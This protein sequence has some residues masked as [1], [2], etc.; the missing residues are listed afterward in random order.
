M[1]NAFRGSDGTLCAV[2]E[3]WSGP[4]TGRCALRVGDVARELGREAGRDFELGDPGSET[5]FTSSSSSSSLSLST[6]RDDSRSFMEFADP[7]FLSSESRVCVRRTSCKR[8]MVVGGSMGCVEDEGSKQGAAGLRFAETRTLTA[9]YKRNPLSARLGSM[10]SANQ[11]PRISSR[12]GLVSDTPRHLARS[13]SRST[14]SSTL[15][16]TTDASS[17]SPPTPRLLLLRAA[18]H[19]RLQDTLVVLPITEGRDGELSD[20]SWRCKFRILPVRVD[21]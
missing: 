15:T 16:S 19:A 5:T 10:T 13:R 4:L 11:P 8:L 12:V 3:R 18:G 2:A 6:C 1:G 14:C 17:S 20:G 9:R 7:S 21:D